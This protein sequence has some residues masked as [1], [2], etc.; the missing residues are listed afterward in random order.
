MWWRYGNFEKYLSFMTSCGLEGK[1]NDAE[2]NTKNQNSH[3]IIWDWEIFNEY[4]QTIMW[5]RFCQI[6]LCKFSIRGR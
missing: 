3:Q 5:D 6:L 2:N 4:S 1:N